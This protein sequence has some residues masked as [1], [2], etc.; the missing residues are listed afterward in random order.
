MPYFM[1]TDRPAV[2]SWSVGIGTLI[3]VAVLLALLPSIGLRGAALAMTLGYVTSGLI[4]MVA[5][6]R[7]SGWSLLET[8]AP[9]RADVV[10]L[11]ELIGHLRPARE[12][13]DGRGSSSTGEK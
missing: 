5:F 12:A 9:R 3:N 8:W 11:L 13:M 6:H 4:L 10:L 1:G 2:C 7:V